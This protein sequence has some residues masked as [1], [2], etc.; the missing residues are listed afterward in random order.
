MAEEID[1]S[2]ISP[3]AM[4]AALRLAKQVVDQREAEMA[5]EAS[6]AAKAE[7]TGAIYA[8]IDS[9]SKEY[10]KN[11]PRIEQL[12]AHLREKYKESI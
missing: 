7:A 11:K 6:A 1:I 8:E 3:E 2:K 10:S 4:Q 5:Q 12:K 9:L